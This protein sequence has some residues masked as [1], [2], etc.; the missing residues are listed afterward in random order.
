MELGVAM[1]TSFARLG[2]LLILS[3]VGVAA[4]AADCPPPAK[5]PAVCM[6]ISNAQK[7]TSGK[8]TF[9]Y[10]KLIY[11]AACVKFSDAEEVRND[12]IRRMWRANEDKLVCNSPRFDVQQGNVLKYAA[13]V[14]FEDFLFDA[15]MIWK[16]DLNRVDPSDGRTVLDYVQKE[17]ERNKG[18]SVESKLRSYYDMLRS[19][20][21]KHQSEL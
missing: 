13:S 14:R 6:A 18:T 17:I 10:E 8:Y 2:A 9:H 5:L 21:A 16:V 3:P 15:A 19:S 11:D 4:S 1:K 12:K 7:D 20:G